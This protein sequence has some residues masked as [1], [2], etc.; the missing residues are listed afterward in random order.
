MMFMPVASAANSVA[1]NGHDGASR[2]G[3][4]KVEADNDGQ[5]N[6]DESDDEIGI[7]GVPS[8]PCGPFISRVPF[9]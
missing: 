9:T 2:T 5:E 7:V 6:E 1:A 3:M 4:D 8:M